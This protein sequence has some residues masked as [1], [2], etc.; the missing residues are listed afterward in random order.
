MSGEIIK[1]CEIV[2][3]DITITIKPTLKSIQA[4]GMNT[5]FKL[6][7]SYDCNCPKLSECIECK[8][9]KNELMNLRKQGVVF[10]D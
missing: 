3:D 9:A 10:W 1:Y 5:G 4:L 7:D 8:I 2:D 6:P